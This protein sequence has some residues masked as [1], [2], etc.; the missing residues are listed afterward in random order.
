MRNLF[1]V[2]LL[3]FLL[4]STAFATT[5][6]A[7]AGGGNWTT[8]GTWVGGVAPTAADDVLLT[9]TSGNVTIDS[10]AV[11]RSLNC[12]GYTGTLSHNGST[13]LTLGD[14]TAGLSNVALKLVSGMTYTKVSNTSSAITFVSTSATQQTIA[15]GGKVLGNV[16]FNGAG[17]NWILS[18]TLLINGSASTNLTLTAGGL[19]TNSQTVSVGAIST[20]NSNV[21]AL[22]ITN[23]SI[24][25][26]VASGNIFSMATSTNMTFSATGSTITLTDTGASD[27]TFASGGK[28]FDAIVINLGGAGKVIFSGGGTYKSFSTALTGTKSVQFTSGTTSTITG[29]SNTPFFSGTSGN[30]VTIS[31]TT[32]ASA[33]TL[34]KASSALFPT[35]VISDYLSVQDITVTGGANWYAGAHSTNVSG[36]TGW[37]FSTYTIFN[38]GTSWT[39][40]A[41][42]QATKIEGWGGGAGGGDGDAG[43]SNTGGA[44]GGSGGYFSKTVTGAAGTNYS[45]TIG[46]GGLGTTPAASCINGAN[47]NATTVTSPSLTANGGVGGG[48]CGGPATGGAGGTASGGDTNTTG[49]TG[50]NSSGNNGGKGGDA[51]NGGAGGAADTVADG[52]GNSGNAPGG[53][54]SGG[55]KT[56][57]G[58]DGVVGRIAFTSVTTTTTSTTTTTVAGSQRG[59]MLLLGIGG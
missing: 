26:N 53:G 27:K 15:T 22:D 40:P 17:G 42:S 54:G 34:S 46:A 31:S 2:F 8:G 10:G 12:T 7:A 19:A 21:R 47:G 57:P 3:Y 58:G 56:D 37:N 6:T 24:N 14:A 32:G 59:R 1:K 43:G 35:Y 45:F 44:G 48:N 23:S 28:T 55:R 36:N 29:T 49:G 9:G 18:D 51:P 52:S 25:L 13:T 30:L 5:I 39:V 11:G 16:T 41:D 33:A 20:N 50:G 4:T 38:S